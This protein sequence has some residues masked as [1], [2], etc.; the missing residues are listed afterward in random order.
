[1]ISRPVPHPLSPDASSGIGR[2]IMR[3]RNVAVAVL[4]LTLSPCHLVT[5]SSA[6]GQ[7]RQPPK[8]HIDKVQVGFFSAQG[9]GFKPGSWT[10][11]YVD[12]TAGDNPIGRADGVIVVQTND[13]DDMENYYTVPLPQLE[14]REQT[15]VLT[16]ARTANASSDLQVVIRAPDGRVL[17]M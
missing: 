16:Y 11:V 1:G 12:L 14:P 13:S 10:P 4:V 5:L 6:L 7:S 17:A 2:P 15:R 9:R 8:V 3:F